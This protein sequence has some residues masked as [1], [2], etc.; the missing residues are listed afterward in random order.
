MENQS[1]AKAL[2]WGGIVFT[3]IVAIWPVLMVA[4]DLQGTVEEQLTQ[5]AEAPGLFMANFFIA[6]LIAPAL[7]ALMLTFTSVKLEKTTP[8]L[9]RIGSLFLGGYFVLVTLSYTAQYAFLPRLLAAGEME[10]A[11][12]WFFEGPASIP[13]YLNQLGYALFGASAF[14]IGYKLLFEGGAPRLIGIALWVSGLLSWMAFFGLALQIEPQ[15]L[16]S[17]L[18]GLLTLPVG[19]MSILWGRKL[20]RYGL[21]SD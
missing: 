5:I 19:I 7:V 18:S 10:L 14:F 9:D 20:L 17:I 8:L 15:G 2:F 21:H 13:Y 16:L 4:S 1:S 11:K 3:L 6:S 12:L